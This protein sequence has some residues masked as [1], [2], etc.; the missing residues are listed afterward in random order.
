[1]KK[2]GYK[3][4]YHRVVTKA[5]LEKI[6]HILNECGYYD[7]MTVDQIKYEEKGNLSYFLLNVDSTTYIRQGSFA[8]L[9]GIF[10]E[11]G[12]V[13]QQWEGIFYLPILIIREMTN[14]KLKPFVKPDM[15]TEHELHHLRHM[16]AHIDQHPGYIKKAMKYNAGSC[17]FDDIQKSI[18]F[19]VSKIFLSELPALVS[20]YENGER[21]YFLYA[22]GWVTMNTSDN[23]DDFIR[24]NLAEYIA[25]L[26]A[27][28]IERFPEKDSEISQYVAKE[29]NRQGKNIF[30]KNTMSVLA[31]ALFKLVSLA[32]KEGKH[33]EVEERYL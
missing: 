5:N 20:D 11:V 28:Y 3:N 32:E 1:M 13:I 17:T 26:R 9:D 2:L 31:I 29:V 16:I 33:Y 6:K 27:A 23:K 22:D 12:S 4:A 14:E 8:M 7:E 10:V 18:K 19:E 21:E 30:G 24:Y 15:L 25:K